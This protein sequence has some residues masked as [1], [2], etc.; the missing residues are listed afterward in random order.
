MRFVFGDVEIDT[1]QVKLTK[2]G[3]PVECEP[4]VF[5][6]LVY[7]CRHPQEAISRAELVEQVWGE[8]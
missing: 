5:E 7:F 2:H 6:L 4:R 1:S 3:F 8:E